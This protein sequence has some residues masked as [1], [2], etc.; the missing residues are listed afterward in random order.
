MCVIQTGTLSCSFSPLI[1]SNEAL[2]A[3]Q[4]AA[5]DPARDIGSRRS[6]LSGAGRAAER[7]RSA[8]CFMLQ[9]LS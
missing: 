1:A 3:E 5:A 9:D 7:G 8:D 2:L 4:A 6:S